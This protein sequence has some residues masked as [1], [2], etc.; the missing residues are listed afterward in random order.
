MTAAHTFRRKARILVFVLVGVVFGLA[1]LPTRPVLTR[2]RVMVVDDFSNAELISN[3][4]TPWRGV[5]DRVMG[6]ISEASV[7]RDVID[8]RPGLRLT[9]DVRL[10]NNGGFIQASLDLT[11]ADGA[12]DVSDFKGV[13][14]LVRGNGERY[15][16]HLRTPDNVRPWQS[17]RAYFT[18]G[19]EW[20]TIDLPFDAFEPYRLQTRL[21]RTQLK[22]I[23][24]GRHWPCVLCRPRR[25]QPRVLSLGLAEKTNVRVDCH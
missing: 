5:S 7:V 21:D 25:G 19:A 22:R 10:E 12:L 23:A 8:G 6:G 11:T 9:G 4:G 1:V 3:F 16:V 15:S 2:D 20:Q 14:L 13:R 17:Y 24:H 18:A